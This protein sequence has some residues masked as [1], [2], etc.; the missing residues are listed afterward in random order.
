MVRRMRQPS[1]N[2]RSL[3]CE[4]GGRSRYGVWTSAIGRRSSSACTVSSVSVSKPLASAGNDLTKR[5][6][7]T[8]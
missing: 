7:I 2:V 4:P 3:L 8:R 6:D 5:R 1:R